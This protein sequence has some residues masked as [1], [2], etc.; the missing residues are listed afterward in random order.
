MNHCVVDK[1]RIPTTICTLLLRMALIHQSRAQSILTRKRKAHTN[2]TAGSV[3]HQFHLTCA[4]SHP[5]QETC[6]CNQM[7]RLI[8]NCANQCKYF[9]RYSKCS[10]YEGRSKISTLFFPK[11]KLHHIF[12]RHLYSHF[13]PRYNY[14][15]IALVSNLFLNVVL[16]FLFF[17]FVLSF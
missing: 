13:L 7:K 4:I 1:L 8:C 5:V 10:K 11:N 17:H 12:Y 6:E 16:C 15:S 9:N 14:S 3:T 2:S